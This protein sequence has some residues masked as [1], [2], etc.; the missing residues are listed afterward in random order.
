MNGMDKK[1]GKSLG[2][3]DHLR[4]SV[5]T[6]LNT[7]PETLVFRRDFGSSFLDI[8]DA[9]M[10]AETLVDFYM[11]IATAVDRWEPRITLTR[12]Q[13]EVS[14]S[15]EVS[16]SMEG[17]YKHNGEAVVLEGLEL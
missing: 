4:Q 1:T 3:V 16:L 15:A 14:Q 5:A 8:L 13:A 6:I 17:Y 7:Q 11:A 12:I 2:G 10:N 9:P